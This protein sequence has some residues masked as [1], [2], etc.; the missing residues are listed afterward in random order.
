MPYNKVPNFQ[1][2]ALDLFA[3]YL[4]KTKKHHLGFYVCENTSCCTY[5]SSTLA[6]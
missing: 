4:F 5:V 6:V 1:C 2:L 3:E